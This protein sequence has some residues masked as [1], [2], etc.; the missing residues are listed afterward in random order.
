MVKRILVGKLVNVVCSFG[1]MEFILWKLTDTTSTKYNWYIYISTCIVKNVKNQCSYKL[2]K[3]E[4]FQASVGK[5][6]FKLLL[7]I[8]SFIF[9]SKRNL[10]NCHSVSVSGQKFQLQLVYDVNGFYGSTIL[11]ASHSRFRLNDEILQTMQ[12]KTSNCSPYFG[13]SAPENSN[14]SR[15]E[16]YIITHWPRSMKTRLRI[17]K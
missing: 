1:C 10:Y 4:L 12:Y 11:E 7:Q 14:I 2:P 6:S 17:K 5:E 16:N 13:H 8:V 15:D 3:N 9:F